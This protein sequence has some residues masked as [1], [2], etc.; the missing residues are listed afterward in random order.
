MLWASEI[1]TQILVASA[2]SPRH[3]VE[4]AKIGADIVTIPPSTLR[5]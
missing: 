5:Q 3:V 4:A 2:R 1:E